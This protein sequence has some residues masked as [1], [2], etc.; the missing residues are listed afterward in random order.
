MA[1][2]ATR[3]RKNLKVD[4]ALFPGVD[5]LNLFEGDLS[6]AAERAKLL[7]DLGFEVVSEHHF[8]LRQNPFGWIQSALNKLPGLPRNGL[9]ALMH[10]RQTGEAL[11]FGLSTAAALL[12]LAAVIAPFAAMATVIETLLRTGATIHVVARKRDRAESVSAPSDG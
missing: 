5:D 2:M 9:Y 4:G 8:S 1:A 7:E 12:V 3:T 10:R 11:P 6:I